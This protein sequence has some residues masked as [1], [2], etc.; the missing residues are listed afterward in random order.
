[1]K[2]VP[3]Q[4]IHTLILPTH[5]HHLATTTKKTTVATFWATFELAEN[6]ECSFWLLTIWFW[7]RTIMVFVEAT[8]GDTAGLIPSTEDSHVISSGVLARFWAIFL[9]KCRDNILI[10]LFRWMRSLV[11]VA[12]EDELTSWT[13]LPEMGCLL[14][15]Q[16]RIG[17]GSPNPEVHFARSSSPRK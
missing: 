9:S 17:F 2:T 16:V 1:M 5:Q 4:K 15:Y 10:V 14:M 3:K 12:G 8:G 11:V 7:S 6:G 13:C